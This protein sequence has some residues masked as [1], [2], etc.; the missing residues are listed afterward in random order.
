[1][2]ALVY[3]FL[4]AMLS[5][6]AIAQQN[7]NKEQQRNKK[8]VRHYAELMKVDAD[9]CDAIAQVESAYKSKAFNNP[10]KPQTDE[11][12]ISR[13]VMQLTFDTGK[14]FNKKIQK[15]D[16]L[17]NAEKNIIA[18]IR[19]IKYLMKK[20]PLSNLEDITQLY[21]LGESK[22]LKGMRNPSYTEK[23]HAIYWDKKVKQF[24]KLSL[25]LGVEPRGQ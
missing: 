11:V 6:T 25:S 8:M 18:G 9:L 5:S 24:K 10:K 21:N 3:I 12:W 15:K 23:F 4:M 20:Y 13:G 14:K 16:D 7:L 22:F 1:M 17:Y 2:K 19:Y